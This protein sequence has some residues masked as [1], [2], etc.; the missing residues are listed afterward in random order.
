MHHL[1]AADHTDADAADASVADTDDAQP[2]ISSQ[3]GGHHHHHAHA[4]ADAD[5]GVAD[6]ADDDQPVVPTDE[7]NDCDEVMMFIADK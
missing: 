6:D 3:P 5:A 4:A 7:S 1:H 2:T